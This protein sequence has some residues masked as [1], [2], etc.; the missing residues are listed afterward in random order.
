MSSKA[1]PRLVLLNRAMCLY[2]Y[3]QA[4]AVPLRQQA[5]GSGTSSSRQKLALADTEWDSE[6]RFLLAAAQDKGQ[7]QKVDNFP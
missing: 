3:R 6:P 7:T 5:T 1:T 4:A 2:T